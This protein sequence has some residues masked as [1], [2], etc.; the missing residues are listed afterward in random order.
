MLVSD[1]VRFVIGWLVALRLVQF[2]ATIYANR[3]LSKLMPPSL[4]ETLQ[5]VNPERACPILL[6][7]LTPILNMTEFQAR[8]CLMFP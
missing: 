3:L 2:K 7:Y 1:L 4:W 6:Y 8:R 5:R